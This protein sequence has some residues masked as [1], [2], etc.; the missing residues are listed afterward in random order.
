MSRLVT[1]T[2]AAVLAAALVSSPAAA[3]GTLVVQ[4][5]GSVDRAVREFIVPKMKALYGVDVSTTPSLSAPALAKAMAQ[6]SSPQIDV[7]MLDA[8]PW[9]QGKAAGLWADLPT[10][11]I[12]NLADVPAD[13]KDAKGVAY[14]HLVI[15][16]LYDTAKIST[17][18][19]SIADLADPKYKGKV[20]VP[21]FSST[22]AFA[23][24]ANL[25]VIAG[26]KGD[27]AKPLDAGFASMKKIAPNVLSFYGGGAQLVNLFKQGEIELAWGANHVAQ[28]LGKDSTVKWTAPVEGAALSTVYAAIAEG[29]KNTD[30]AAQFINL[31]LSPEFQA[32]MAEQGG[33]AFVNTKT[34]LSPDYAKTSPLTREVIAAGKQLPWD[35]FNANRIVLNERWQRDIEAK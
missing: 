7:F 24:L 16:F 31:L 29:T 21:T 22:F 1:A 19:K 4:T 32:L 20:A 30:A 9:L 33:V 6:K 18:P 35:V 10:A 8:G 28:G 14:T 13:L 27:A 2:C 11:K 3:Q 26:G 17:P 23:L 15:G 25:D 34:E 5:Q 12:P